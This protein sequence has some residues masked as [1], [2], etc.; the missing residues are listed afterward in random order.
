LGRAVAIALVTLD[1]PPC[2]AASWISSGER[3]A[4]HAAHATDWVRTVDGWEPRRVIE[5]FELSAPSAVHPAVIAGFQLLAS[6]FFLAAFPARVNARPAPVSNGMLRTH[7]R[8]TASS[9]AVG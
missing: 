1:L 7:L 4:G 5:P 2:S 6:L 8:P 3:T 9:V